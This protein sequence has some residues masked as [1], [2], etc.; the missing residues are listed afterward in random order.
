MNKPVLLT[1]SGEIPPD[2]RMQIEEGR[3]PRADYLELARKIDADLI[4]YRAARSSTGLLGRALE[5]LGGANAML[6]YACWKVRGQ[7]RAIVTDGEQVGL[8]LALILKLRPGIRPAHLMIVHIISAAKKLPFLDWFRVHSHIDRFL[9]YSRWQ[10]RFIERRW[11]ISGER[12]VWTPFMV[13]QYFFS[14]SQVT[15]Q[16]TSRPQI[17]AVGLE[18]R[19]YPT[20]MR[21]VE[22]LDLD[23][24]VAA[25]SPW[26][27][28]KDSTSGQHIPENVTV[29]KFSQYDLR[30]LYADS[31]F[32]VM[33][34]EEVDF[35][36]GV[37]AILEAM[38]MAKPV[39]CSR[40]PGQKDVIIEN[41][42]GR[43]V[44]SGDPMALRAAIV[45]LLAQ[46]EEILRLGTSARRQVEAQ[47]NLDLYA[48]GLAAITRTTLDEINIPARAEQI[49]GAP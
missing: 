5:W 6:A 26:S 23:V 11:N 33:P 20:L 10:K 47:M 12:V 30:Q 7:Y 49:S 48:E 19:D 17:C 32:L 42:N 35:Q 25:A 45:S 22:G 14:P 18:R 13:D 15:P 27:K 37:T 31:L 40:V 29:K 28:Y 21:A 9:V 43:Y 41:E 3:R 4:D 2:V 36:A 39:I 1:V 8:P 24:V 38:A 34:L 46:P 16:T 44:E